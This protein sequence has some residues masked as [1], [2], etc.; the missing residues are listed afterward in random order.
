MKTCVKCS[1]EKPLD[2]F[3]RMKPT[4]FNQG[5]KGY[6]KKCEQLQVEKSRL[7]RKKLR[8]EDHI[9]QQQK[10]IGR[11]KKLISRNLAFVFRYLRL[12]GKC[13]D[14]GTTD[15]RVLE[16]DHVS[17]DKVE[18]VIRMASTTSTIDN[19][20]K[21]IKKCELRCCNCHRI[22]TQSQLGWRE[23]WKFDWL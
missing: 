21:E 7:K 16:F 14:C 12:C 18:G 20:K 15:I 4:K 9:L 17:G 22:K 19:I 5:V 6:C 1:I 2:E 23:N 8:P 11:N 10:T 13:V 3:G